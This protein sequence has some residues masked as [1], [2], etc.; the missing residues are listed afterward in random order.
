M[1]NNTNEG[2]NAMFIIWGT[3]E[4]EKELGIS[5]QSYQ[6][7]HCNNV[8]NYKIFRRKNW[9]T[10]FWIPIIPLSSKYFISCPICNYGQKIKKAEALEKIQ[11]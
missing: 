8:S 1:K 11:Q 10:V 3:R 2:V 5:Q 6:C 4:K 9:F 7:T